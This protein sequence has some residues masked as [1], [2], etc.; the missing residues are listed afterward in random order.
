MAG[1][2]TIIRE[3]KGIVMRE[4]VEPGAEDI[5]RH[6]VALNDEKYREAMLAF[7]VACT[8]IIAINRRQRVFYLAHRNILPKKTWWCFGGRTLRGETWFA[9]AIR[10]MK[11]E[12]GLELS[13]DRLTPIAFHRYIMKT[14]QQMPQEAGADNPV[15]V[16][17]FEPTSVE[18]DI[19]FGNLDQKEYLD[20]GIRSFTREQMIAAN[21]EPEILALHHDVFGD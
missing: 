16:F 7:P 2:E 5:G 21:V 19:M 15:V 13:A 18:L 6:N 3:I 20:G 10:K 11:L 9:S 4:F 12:T 8:D 14:R 17:I 1:T